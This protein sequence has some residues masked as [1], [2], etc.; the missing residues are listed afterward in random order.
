MSVYS[1]KQRK[2]FVMGGFDGWESLNQAEVITFKEDGGVE[3]VSQLPNMPMR[4]KNGVAVLDEKSDAIFVIGGWDEKETMNSVFRF[5]ATDFSCDFHG[6]L[7]QKVE[8]HA[9]VRIPNTSTIFIFGGFDGLGVTDRVMS[10]DFGKRQANVLYGVNLSEA[11][12]NLVAELIGDDLIVV[13]S[14][15]NGHASSAT[16][17]L[18]RYDKGT[19]S[20]TRL[21]VQ[22][23]GPGLDSFS[24][25]DQ[26]F[27]RSLGPMGA[28][29]NRPT[30]LAI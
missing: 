1:K 7:P 26:M 20:L 11:R 30:S 18:F 5:G 19:K 27:L 16:I 15:W 17:D 10:Y 9:C 12:E 14:G 2:V 29:R 6:F 28:K 23:M 25:E 21:D 4:V 22:G 24:R 8:G 3:S 13:S